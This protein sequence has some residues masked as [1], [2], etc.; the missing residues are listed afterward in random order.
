MKI[1]AVMGSPRKLETLKAVQRFEEK[2]A[3]RREVTFNY[4]FLK[5]MNIKPCKGCFLCIEKGEELC[6]QREDDRIKI[7]NLMM[8]ADGVIFASP[9]YSLQV[10]AL[11]KNFLDRMA[12][13]FHRPC[14]FHK[15]FVPIITQ[16]VYGG[17]EILKYLETI[18]S[19]WGFNVTKGVLVSTPPGVRLPAEEAKIERQINQGVQRFYQTLTGDPSPN[20]SLKKFFIFSLICAFKP[21]GPKDR[22]YEYF[23]EK[24]W[25]E[26]PYYYETKLPLHYRIIGWLVKLKFSKEGEK[27]QQLLNRLQPP[28]MS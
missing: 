11:M 21:Y 16:G 13:V 3:A 19:F 1:V 27:R 14:F 12:Y 23:Q 20:P 18:G 26:S 28:S 5:E 10:T 17:E 9:N 7:F 4:I 15:A 22:D 24:G 25:L 6:P 2:L 8:D